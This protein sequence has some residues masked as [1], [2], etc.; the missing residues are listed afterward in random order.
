MMTGNVIYLQMILLQ[1]A[2]SDDRATFE[3]FIP[4]DNQGGARLTQQDADRFCIE[5]GCPHHATTILM[6]DLLEVTNFER[7][8][9]KIDI[10][11][12]EHRAFVHS[13]QLF[14]S[15]HVEYI[16]MEWV[17]LREYYGA[18]VDT[19][20]DKDKVFEMIEKLDMRGYIPKSLIDFKRL[21]LV[22]WYGWPH[23]VV[24]V[25]KDIPE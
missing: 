9:L 4:S 3:L 16:V 5:A 10:E 17:K 7:A 20:D 14:K 8:V 15:V 11:G 12:H 19:S 6:D 25:H 18:E 22:H 23:D 21:S 1:N 13:E 2:V 24:W